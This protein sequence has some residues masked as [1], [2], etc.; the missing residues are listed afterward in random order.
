MTVEVRSVTI[1]TSVNGTS[2]TVTKP[3]GTAEGD[4]LIASVLTN[5]ESVTQ[6][7]PPLDWY[8][9]QGGGINGEDN[10]CVWYKVAG[11]S[12]P[13]DYT[14]T[15]V[16][17]STTG[18]GLV[19][20]RSTLSSPLTIG[21]VASLFNSSS[22]NRTYPSVTFSKAGLMLC[23][24]SH[25]ISFGSTPPV[26]MTE[27]WDATISSNRSYCMH[28]DISSA[29]TTAQQIA[30]GTA[31]DSRCIS[32]A[33][34]EGVT[35]YPG[36]RLRDLARTGPTT[37]STSISLALPTVSVGD[38]IVAH[39][40]LNANSTVVTPTGWE[41][42]AN[43]TNP[44]EMCVFTKVAEAGDI[45]S[46]L[47]VN[48][49][50]GA[51]VALLSISTY[52]SPDGYTLSIG[53]IA[54]T[55]ESAASSNTFPSVTSTLDGSILVMLLSKQANTQYEL[56]NNI[57]M[58]EEYDYGSASGRSAL[59]TKML[60]SIGATGT[61]QAH[62]T[63]GTSAAN[64]VSLLIEATP[65]TQQVYPPNVNWARDL[66]PEGS[67]NRSFSSI[68]QPF[69]PQPSRVRPS[70]VNW[71]ATYP[72]V[73]PPPRD[74]TP[75]VRNW[76]GHRVHTALPEEVTG[77]ALDDPDSFWSVVVPEATENLVT[78]PSFENPDSGL[79]GFSSGDWS[80]G[81]NAALSTEKVRAGQYSL[82]GTSNGSG[83]GYMTY[84][85]PS[86][87]TAG[88]PYTWS[89]DW[90]GYRGDTYIVLIEDDLGV[91]MYNRTF[92]SQHSGWWRYVFTFV[93]RSGMDLSGVTLTF[94]TSS[95]TPSGKAYYTDRWQ[96]EQKAYPTTYADG[97]MLG[98]LEDPNPYAYAWTGKP[99]N[100]SS[101][102]SA[103]TTTGGKIVSLSAYGLKTTTVQG[104]GM[105]DS[106]VETYGLRQPGDIIKKVTP[107]N[108]EFV[109]TG[110]VFGRNDREVAEKRQ[111]IIN[112]LRP[113]W[114][115]T[116]QPIRLI[117]QP[118]SP[119]GVKVGQP[120]YIDCICRGGLAG[121]MTNLYQ[122]T[123]SLQF[124]AYDPKLYEDGIGGIGSIDSPMLATAT[125]YAERDRNH[126]W[127]DKGSGSANG[128]V[129]TVVFDGNG[130][131]WV[132]GGF[133][134]FD[135]SA[136]DYLVKYNRSTGAW[137]EIGDGINGVV[138]QVALSKHP[139]DPRLGFVGNF[140]LSGADDV[141]NA[142]YYDVATDDLV[143]MATG[144]DDPANAIAA[145]FSGDF[146]VGGS[147]LN[148]ADLTILIRYIAR[149]DVAT[150]TWD[151]VATGVNDDVRCI[152]VGKDG[153]VYVGGNFTTSGSGGTSLGRVAKYN[154]YTD[155]WVQMDDGFN[156][157]VYALEFGPDGFLYAGGNFTEDAGGT[158]D[159]RHIARWNGR[160]W[161]EVGGG[162]NNV[163]NV[164]R[165]VGKY[166][167]VTGSFTAGGNGL[168]SWAHNYLVRWDGNQWVPS[169]YATE[170]VSSIA[171]L[172]LSSD[173]RVALAANESYSANYASLSATVTNL[174]TAEVRPVIYLAEEAIYY[175]ITNV[176]TNQSIFFKKLQTYTGEQVVLDF[177]GVKPRFYS[178]YRADLTP[179]I[180]VSA[181][182]YL[183]F[184][185]VQGNN[186]IKVMA[187]DDGSLAQVS[188]RIT[189]K[190][191]HWSYDTAGL[192]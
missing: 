20:V 118:L 63:S 141:R 129:Q 190:N 8:K 146:Y 115:E 6:F 48:F 132:G 43:L 17:T 128:V 99:H 158:R 180:L 101:I 52:F 168:P 13:A 9:V 89:F 30:T 149:W 94:M 176:T 92:I 137:E 153:M 96:L 103:T 112:A 177:T 157:D 33:I 80:G 123:L 133:T 184:R 142:G 39:L 166:M 42:Q 139:T 114:M 85:V 93:P 32:L 159:L 152:T 38:M 77:Y 170:N 130:D 135:G 155:A 108:R 143:E 188:T 164:L 58:W 192:I 121:N 125:G 15:G 12:E 98:H 122:E 11:A 119:R 23:L 95:A 169:D 83:A 31:L 53:D 46:T 45:S 71:G 65:P 4:L 36:V 191:A 107:A 25:S 84:T 18:V 78:N 68:N 174:G 134:Q 24:G 76:G 173:G 185:L 160:V 67:G 73:S 138:G 56:I 75:Q 162:L 109:L 82:K 156:S 40:T 136:L 171:R 47:T 64:L 106:E 189:W 151:E 144:L 104:L 57:D 5:V 187:K 163:V 178:N 161:E 62:N 167:Y 81:G 179:F 150:N 182:N 165:T 186:V 51:T 131:P 97:D 44:G 1:P 145:H 105:V 59:F 41:L 34:V 37:T 54:T 113:R 88:L 49:S 29:G 72:N 111:G 35:T 181:S 148:D 110:K 16:S 60:T 27:A 79:T 126:S 50:G 172:A 69:N 117:Y 70:T 74:K 26:G 7:K 124:T 127:D 175:E 3:T 147:F 2:H 28:R 86:T 116:S 87:L 14:F 102:R 22:A 120:L 61:L 154:P 66:L 21:N 10:I 91:D 100:S 140:G 55:E 183:D 90:Y 19:C